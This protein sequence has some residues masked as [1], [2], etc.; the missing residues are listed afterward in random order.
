MH[1][2]R[3]DPFIEGVELA[4]AEKATAQLYRLYRTNQLAG[5][6]AQELYRPHRVDLIF[7]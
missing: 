1:R 6:K 5:A 2:K 7:F 4:S 3:H